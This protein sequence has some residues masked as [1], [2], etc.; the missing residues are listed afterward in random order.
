MCST[1]KLALSEKEI[2]ITHGHEYR[3]NLHR[4]LYLENLIADGQTYGG[5]EI[6]AAVAKLKQERDATRKLLKL[7]INKH[8]G[9]TFR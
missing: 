3:R 2:K 4:L 8:F 7:C 5:D 1:D 6:K 9:S